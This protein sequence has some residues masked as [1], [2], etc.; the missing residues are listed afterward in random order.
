MISEYLTSLSLIWLFPLLSLALS[1]SSIIRQYPELASTTE[2]TLAFGI[3][4]TIPLTVVVGE[5]FT[6][7]GLVKI[8]GVYACVYLAIGFDHCDHAV[9]PFS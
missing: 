6:L 7:N 9:D 4:D 1:S 8:S 5:M 2:N 3:L